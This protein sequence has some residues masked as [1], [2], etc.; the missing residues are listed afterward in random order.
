MKNKCIFRYINTCTRCS[1]NSENSEYCKVH[2]NNS[3]IIYNIVDTVFVKNKINC[4]QSY[5]YKLYEYIQNDDEIYTKELMFKACLKML[6]TKKSKL[7]M[8]YPYLNDSLSVNQIIDEI[9]KLS[10]NTNRM[11]RENRNKINKIVNF[12]VNNIYN[13]LK[14][15]NLEDPF[16]FDDIIDIP[17]KRLFKFKEN[18][19]VY[20]FDVLEFK[21]YINNYDRINP[22]TKKELS[23]L[24][25]N[26][27]NTFIH[28]NNL[29]INE[30]ETKYKQHT[31]M[32]CY[33]KVSQLLE[34]IG[35]Y[36]NVEW[37]LKIKLEDI[38]LIIRTFH[39]ISIDIPEHRYYMKRI[40]DIK[41]FCD[42][43]I[44]LFENGTDNFLLCCMFIKSLALYSDDFYNNI[45]EWLT[46]IINPIRVVQRNNI[47]Y[48][49]QLLEY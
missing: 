29:D 17:S 39:Y 47:Y 34:K 18:N 4:N 46:D 24:I 38:H 7:L 26:K 40:S 42:E 41:E 19:H 49:I 35:F 8:M 27:I 14:P 36:N 33:T 31:I 11:I 6:F 44:K 2:F 16:T 15:E 45:P 1:M 12:F 20:A 5:L 37:F 28:I 3:N 25:L 23:E 13:N 48:L 9:A 22:Y 21:Y 10:E 43:I 30:I 32:Q